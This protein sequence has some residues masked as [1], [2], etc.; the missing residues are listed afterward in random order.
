FDRAPITTIHG[1]C[2]R[3][4]DESAFESRQPFR[5]DFVV[6]PL[7]LLRRAAADV[8]R[9][10]YAAEP[11]LLHAVLALSELTPD[12]LASAYRVWQRH[13]GAALEPAEPRVADRLAAIEAPL[14]RAAAA[15]D[16]EAHDFLTS[17]Q[18]R[19]DKNPF[20]ADQVT[21]LRRCAAQLRQA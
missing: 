14:A 18:W 5:L 6:D 9:R 20:D 2:K 13:P 10:T 17:C 3:L 4:L 19:K 11:T 15:F 12:S 8:L 21:E 1:F 16:Q 7:P